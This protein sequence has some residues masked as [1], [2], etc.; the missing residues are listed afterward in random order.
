M[1]TVC[2]VEASKFVAGVVAGSVLAAWMVL[3][4]VHVVIWLVQENP[5][6]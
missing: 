6:G 5:N 3:L 4:L 2:G 1:K